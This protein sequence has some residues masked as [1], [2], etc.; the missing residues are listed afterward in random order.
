MPGFLKSKK[1]PISNIFINGCP[2]RAFSGDHLPEEPFN[3]FAE[4][5]VVQIGKE[6]FSLERIGFNWSSEG[7]RFPMRIP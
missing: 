5:V 6:D 3:L 7:F 1:D 2:D 4:A